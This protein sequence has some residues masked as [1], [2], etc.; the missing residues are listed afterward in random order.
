MGSHDDDYILVGLTGSIGAG[1]SAVATIFEACGIPVL[2]ADEIARELME[3]DPELIAA[4]VLEFGADAY[5][6]GKL[7]RKYLADAIFGDAGRLEA[8]NALVHPRTIAE[9]GARA[10]ALVAS[11]A[12]VV[13]CEA[14]LIFES[15]GE[16][17]F[18]YLVVVD[19]ERDIR[20]AR[21][22][23]RDGVALDEIARRDASQIPAE[24]KVEMADFVIRND[25]APADLERNARFVATLLKS[26]PPRE[27]IETIEAEDGQDNGYAAGHDDGHAD[28]GATER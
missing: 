25:G 27:R 10:G 16:G 28:T 23:E 26:L 7:N 18:D 21:A 8:M 17:R 20:L 22:A 1:K 15:G 9:Q 5:V 12:R 14:A 19:A 11:G 13:A 6:D 3:T 4:I 2:R 24:R